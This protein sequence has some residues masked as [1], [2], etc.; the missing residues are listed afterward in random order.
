MLK[1]NK[2]T[3]FER[4]VSQG[5]EKALLKM[6]EMSKNADYIANVKYDIVKVSR[7][8]VEIIAYGTAIY[9]KNGSNQHSDQ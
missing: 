2:Q 7:G 5:K 8:F 6:K 9:L 1:M 3:R 4:V